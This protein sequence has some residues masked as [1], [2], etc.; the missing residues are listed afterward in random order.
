VQYGPEDRQSR[1]QSRAIRQ[2]DGALRGSGTGRTW[3]VE[4][5]PGVGDCELSAAVQPA[6]RSSDPIDDGH[7]LAGDFPP[8]GIEGNGEHDATAR[9]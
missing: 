1:H 3:N 5:V 9:V 8:V 2:R 6:Q 4:Q 7:R